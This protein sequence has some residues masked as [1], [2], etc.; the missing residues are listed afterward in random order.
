LALGCT[1]AHQ[2][3]TDQVGDRIGRHGFLRSCRCSKRF[4]HLVSNQMADTLIGFF[5][6]TRDM[7]GQNQIG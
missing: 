2:G 1:A 6:N 5:G 7:R 4:E 3:A